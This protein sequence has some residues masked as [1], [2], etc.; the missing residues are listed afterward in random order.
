MCRLCFVMVVLAGGL[1]TIL[2]ARLQRGA[3]TPPRTTPAPSSGRQEVVPPPV[4]REALNALLTAYDAGDYAT[5]D[6]GAGRFARSISNWQLFP[7]ELIPWI[8]A[9]PQTERRRLVAASVVLEFAYVQYRNPAAGQQLVEMGCQLLQLQAPVPAER[10]WHIAAVELVRSHTQH[11][12]L[13]FPQDGEILLPTALDLEQQRAPDQE[14]IFGANN[15]AVWLDTAA[16]DQ[17][18]AGGIDRIKDVPANRRMD[19]ASAER[20][21]QI[22]PELKTV[23]TGPPGTEREA[24]GV[25]I[26]LRLWD[27]ADA[28]RSVVKGAPSLADPYLRLGQTYVRLAR[29]VEAIE[30]FKR[31]DENAIQDGTVTAKRVRYLA[32]LLAGGVFERVGRRTEAMELFRGALAVAPR[33]QSASLALAPLLFQTGSRDEASDVLAAAV[34]A[35]LAEDPLQT[36]WERD[37]D[38]WARQFAQLRKAMR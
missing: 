3:S 16:V 38:R 9:A 34:R 30:A 7:P 29:P 5:F 22:A 27:V 23:R 8:A 21:I 2:D 6:R 10:F 35:P 11:A 1:G 33:A 18:A 15:P 20:L 26:S 19:R 36:Y 25:T 13:R 32:R 28:F 31:A 37:P 24:N 4:D 17:I 12:V 14:T